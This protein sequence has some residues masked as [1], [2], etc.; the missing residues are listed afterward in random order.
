[1]HAEVQGAPLAVTALR[2]AEEAFEGVRGHVRVGTSGQPLLHLLAESH[3]GHSAGA[4]DHA[5]PGSRAQAAG[6]VDGLMAVPANPASAVRHVVS[7]PASDPLTLHGFTPAD[8]GTNGAC[9]NRS[10]SASTER[11][12]T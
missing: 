12:T 9:G 10:T 6:D 5:L 7:V 1:M 2:Q 8:R 4:G 11:S 3:Y